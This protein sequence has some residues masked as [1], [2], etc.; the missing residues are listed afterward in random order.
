MLISIICNLN[1]YSLRSFSTI[2][3]KMSP[4]KNEI[5][6]DNAIKPDTISVGKLGTNPVCK[7]KK[8]PAQTIS[9]TKQIVKLTS[10]QRSSSV[11]NFYTIFQ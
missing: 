10:F 7:Y 4:E 6:A 8:T 5:N 11:Y 3:D 9:E 1:S 2:S